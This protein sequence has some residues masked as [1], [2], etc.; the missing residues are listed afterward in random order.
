MHHAKTKHRENVVFFS[1]M[2]R[3]E[4]LTPKKLSNQEQQYSC[5][6]FLSNLSAL[7]KDSHLHIKRKSKLSFHVIPKAVILSK[8]LVCTKDFAV[9]FLMILR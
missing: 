1:E 4:L 2:L 3:H 5:G 8:I 7:A 9:S 6:I